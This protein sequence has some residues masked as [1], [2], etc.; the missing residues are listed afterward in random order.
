MTRLQNRVGYDWVSFSLGP[1]LLGSIHILRGTPVQKTNCKISEIRP[2]P[3]SLIRFLLGHQWH[4]IREIG[5]SYIMLKPGCTFL[6]FPLAVRVILVFP[7]EDHSFCS[8]SRW[9][10]R[11]WRENIWSQFLKWM[12]S[13]ESVMGVMGHDQIKTMVLLA[14][15]INIM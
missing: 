11:A 15:H 8:R 9:V 6:I 4:L 2:S 5:F 7:W 10:I 13:K 12:N 3:I 14:D 1:P